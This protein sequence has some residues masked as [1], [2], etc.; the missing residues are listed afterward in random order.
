MNQDDGTNR[1][2]L[3]LYGVNPGRGPTIGNS[4]HIAD[5]FGR[6]I[7]NGGNRGG[8]AIEGA[9]DQWHHA[10]LYQLGIFQDVVPADGLERRAPSLLPG[11][12]GQLAFTVGRENLDTDRGLLDDRPEHVVR[13][14]FQCLLQCW[15]RLVGHAHIVGGIDAGPIW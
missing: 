6:D 12:I 15:M 11:P 14:T 3:I 8:F 1:A 10:M 2:Q 4:S 9:F 13:D 7:P 5:R